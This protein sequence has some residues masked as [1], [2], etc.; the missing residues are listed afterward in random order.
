MKKILLI[1][2]TGM[3]GSAIIPLLLKKGYSVDALSLDDLQS[4]DKNLRYIKADA[5]DTEFLRELF[6]D[7]YIAKHS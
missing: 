7:D 1:G 4:S 3:M 6:M 2:G 5:F